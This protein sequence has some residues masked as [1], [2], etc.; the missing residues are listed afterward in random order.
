MVI[1][2]RPFVCTGHDPIS[3]LHGVAELLW[4]GDA[5]RS[6][7]SFDWC[8]TQLS[9]REK[10]M[11]HDI[12]QFLFLFSQLLMAAQVIVNAQAMT[13]KAKPDQDEVLPSARRGR[14]CNS[15]T[16]VHKHFLSQRPMFSFYYV[17]ACV[18]MCIQE[19]PQKHWFLTSNCCN[20]KQADE[21]TSAKG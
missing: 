9:E 17:S 7:V 11:P 12:P 4:R 15:R 3:R 8:V 6:Y 18:Q 2:V 16:R 14:E 10:Q 5:P 20:H 19:Q 1:V 13:R 21:A